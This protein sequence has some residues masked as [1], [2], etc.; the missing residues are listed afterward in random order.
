MSLVRSN[1]GT[2]AIYCDCCGAEKLAEIRDGQLI[3]FDRRHGVRHTAVLALDKLIERPQTVV[4]I[5]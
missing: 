2:K 4:P 5:E 3:I 1:N